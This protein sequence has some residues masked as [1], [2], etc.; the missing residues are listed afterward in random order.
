MFGHDGACL[1][2]RRRAQGISER[3][4]DSGF[5]TRG[6]GLR[7]PEQ[8]P[9]PR[10]VRGEYATIAE[11]V[12]NASH[13]SYPTDPYTGTLSVGWCGKRHDRKLASRASRACGKR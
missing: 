11:L 7:R 12:A 8:P 3:F 10:N 5:A 9:W 4:A 1:P 13:F 2:Q 6:I